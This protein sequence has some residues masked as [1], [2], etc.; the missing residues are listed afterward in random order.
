MRERRKQYEGSDDAILRIL[1]E[2]SERA[3]DVTEKTLALAK[4]AAGAGFFTRTVTY[5]R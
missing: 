2:G 4:E 3:I 5:S 1:K